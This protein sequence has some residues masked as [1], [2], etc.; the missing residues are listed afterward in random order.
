MRYETMTTLAPE[1]ALAAAEQFFAGELGLTIERQRSQ[2][3]SF[4]GGGGHVLVSIIRERPT[5][6]EI[7]TREWDTPVTTFV[8]KLPR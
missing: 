1:E 8:G 7:E 6:L 5:T 4:V 3:I 2:E